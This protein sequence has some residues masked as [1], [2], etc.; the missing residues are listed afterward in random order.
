MSILKEEAEVPAIW[1]VGGLFPAPVAQRE[2][3]GMEKGDSPARLPPFM[4][5]DPSGLCGLAVP[6]F[7]NSRLDLFEVVG[8]DLITLLAGEEV[9]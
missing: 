7:A 2:E 6:M 4:V 3:V 8:E 5:P 9:C 1:C